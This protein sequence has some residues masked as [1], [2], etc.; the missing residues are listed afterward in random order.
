MIVIPLTVNHIA[1][2]KIRHNKSQYDFFFSF[3]CISPY[4][5]HLT[6]EEEGDEAGL[7][8]HVELETRAAEDVFD[9]GLRAAGSL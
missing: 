3:H 4:Y 5:Y 8:G 7:L 2:A 9:H 6:S 1:I